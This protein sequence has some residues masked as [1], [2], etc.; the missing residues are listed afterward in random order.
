[1]WWRGFAGWDCCVLSRVEDRD[2]VVWMSPGEQAMHMLGC[3]WRW[4]FDGDL[5]PA[6]RKESLII[7]AELRKLHGV[8]SWEP[9]ARVVFVYT[10]LSQCILSIRSGS[11]ESPWTMYQTKMLWNLMKLTTLVP[12]TM[13]CVVWVSYPC[14]WDNQWLH[15]I[16]L[17]IY[18][19]S[20][21][22]FIND[23]N[24]NKHRAVITKYAPL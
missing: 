18:K 3:T 13:T 23:M 9:W 11:V 21:I 7:P 20:V 12:D 8:T 10:S 19:I 1:M 24:C 5:R 14:I 6:W 15:L 2:T 17:V 16:W 4:G 22:F